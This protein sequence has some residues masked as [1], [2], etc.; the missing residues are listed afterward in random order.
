MECTFTAGNAFCSDAIPATFV[1]L[2][3]VKEKVHERGISVMSPR[4]ERPATKFA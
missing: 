3:K 1:R 2:Q 4:Q